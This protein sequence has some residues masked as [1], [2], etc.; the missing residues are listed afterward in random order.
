V[1]LD[2]DHEADLVAHLGAS[3]VRTTVF[4]GSIVAG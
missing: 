4:S 2:T 3:A 1:V